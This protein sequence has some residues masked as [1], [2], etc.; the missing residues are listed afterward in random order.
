[1]DCFVAALFAMTGKLHGGS[2]RAGRISRRRNPPFWL[3]DNGG[4]CCANPPYELGANPPSAKT[5][6]AFLPASPGYLAASFRELHHDLQGMIGRRGNAE[7]STLAH[8]IAVEKIDLGRLAA[9][10]ILR[11]G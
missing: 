11:G 6:L 7:F 3:I 5:T 9:R 2:E 1:M 8:D 4:L 10:E